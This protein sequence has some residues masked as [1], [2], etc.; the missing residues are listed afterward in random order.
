MSAYLRADREGFPVYLKVGG[1]KEVFKVGKEWKRYSFSAELP[2][3]VVFV[4]SL[5]ETG[6]LLVAATQLEEPENRIMRT[7]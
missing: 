3:S 5:E 2:K 4:V 1:K 6:T 7:R